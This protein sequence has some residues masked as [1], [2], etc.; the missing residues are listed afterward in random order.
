MELAKKIYEQLSSQDYA[1]IPYK[2][3]T[4]KAIGSI[5]GDGVAIKLKKIAIKRDYQRV[6]DFEPLCNKIVKRLNSSS[7]QVGKDWKILEI[8]PDVA[9][10]VSATFG[11][12]ENEYHSYEININHAGLDFGQYDFRKY[13]MPWKKEGDAVLL[14]S[15]LEDI[16][17]S[18]VEGSNA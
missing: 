16:L 11:E 3:D 4:I 1:E 5:I 6:E 10:L 8:G 9:Q 18:L 13:G 2:E 12:K 14:Q 7:N 17:S 15:Q